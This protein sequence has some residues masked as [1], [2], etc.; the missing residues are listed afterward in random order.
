[1]DDDEFVLN[2]S[3]CHVIQFKKFDFHDFH[4]IISRHTLLKGGKS[5]SEN[6]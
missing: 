2:F 6:K 3:F 4:E 5:D 1:M